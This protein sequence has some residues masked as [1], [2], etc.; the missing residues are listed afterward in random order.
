MRRMKGISAL[1]AVIML[2]AFTMIVAGILAGWA[3]QFV[4]QQRSELSLCSKA[5]IL[6]QNANHANGKLTVQIFNSGDVELTGFSARITDRNETTKET[7]TVPYRMG[8]FTISPQ[9]IQPYT[10]DVNQ[11]LYEVVIQSLQCK[12]AQDMIYKYDITGLA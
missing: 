12:G 8:N 5:G 6:I 9:T 3:T 10:F 11:T 7:T 1:I 2:I 4:E